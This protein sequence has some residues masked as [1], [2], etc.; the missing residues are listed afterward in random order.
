MAAVIPTNVVS[1]W[2]QQASPTPSV[3]AET[4]MSPPAEGG[5][6]PSAL[7]HL[8]SQ[9]SLPLGSPSLLTMPGE[10]S[11]KKDAYS[12]QEELEVAREGEG[13]GGEASNVPPWEE[14]PGLP[15]DEQGEGALLY[16]RGNAM[17]ASDR[18][19]ASFRT[20][21]SNVSAAASFYSASGDSVAASSQREFLR[22][23]SFRSL[24][25]AEDARERADTAVPRDIPRDTSGTG[26]VVAG[27]DSTPEARQQESSRQSSEAL[28]KL[29]VLPGVAVPEGSQ[30]A[31]L[32]RDDDANV[33]VKGKE[34]ETGDSGNSRE[35]TAAFLKPAQFPALAE[36]R[37]LTAAHAWHS[38]PSEIMQGHAATAVAGDDATPGEAQQRAELGEQESG[39]GQ[40]Q[41]EG[42]GILVQGLQ[43]G[44]GEG[45]V[46][47]GKVK[48]ELT[49][50]ED[51]V[52][53][54]LP[55]VTAGSQQE[56]EA[57]VP[58][59]RE[60]SGSVRVGNSVLP[61]NG[62]V[63]ATVADV[64]RD[65]LPAV[66]A[67]L[68][69]AP[70]QQVLG[71]E[72]ASPDLGG[73]ERSWEALA[74]AAEAAVSGDAAAASDPAQQLPSTEGMETAVEDVGTHAAATL[75]PSSPLKAL[76]AEGQLALG[77]ASATTRPALA[78]SEVPGNVHQQREVLRDAASPLEGGRETGETNR[79]EAEEEEKVQ[80]GAE[81][82]VGRELAEG[83]AVG[84][85]LDIVSPKPSSP[86]LATEQHLPGVGTNHLSKLEVPHKPSLVSQMLA[87]AAAGGGGEGWQGRGE[88]GEGS[89]SG[90][91]SGSGASRMSP[92]EVLQ[93]K[94]ALELSSSSGSS[95]S[96]GKFW[97]GG[98]GSP[99]GGDA[100]G[101]QVRAG[102]PTGEV[103]TSHF[104][105]ESDSRGEEAPVMHIV[106][107]LDAQ[108]LLS[109]GGDSS[110]MRPL[111]DIAPHSLVGHDEGPDGTVH[112]GQEIA[113]ALNHD[114]GN[115]SGSSKHS[116]G[117]SSGKEE[118]AVPAQVLPSSP[119]WGLTRLTS[120]REAAQKHLAEAP[121][122]FDAAGASDRGAA[123]RGGE[124]L[125]AELRE[126]Q[127]QGTAADM[128]SSNEALT[129]VLAA[130]YNVLP[131]DEWGSRTA[132]PIAAAGA[133]NGDEGG[134]GSVPV[135][136]PGG[137]QGTHEGL[138]ITPGSVAQAIHAFEK[139]ARQVLQA[140]DVLG[141]FSAGRRKGGGVEAPAPAAA[142]AA[143]AGGHGA[144]AE[145][146]R[147]GSAQELQVG[148]AVAA[149]AVALAKGLA[150]AHAAHASREADGD[151]GGDAAVTTLSAVSPLDDTRAG[152][153]G[154]GDA[155]QPI[156]SDGVHA[157]S[158]SSSRTYFPGVSSMSTLG[159]TRQSLREG[160]MEE[161]EQEKEQGR[162]GQGQ[163][164]GQGPLGVSGSSA[165]GAPGGILL[166]E[167]PALQSEE[168]EEEDEE[169]V[170]IAEP[171]DEGIPVAEPEEDDIPIAEPDDIPIA[172]YEEDDI[173]I[174]E[175]D[176][177][178]IAE[179]DEEDIPIAKPDDIPLAVPDEEDIPIAE[180]DDTP[181][182]EP[183]E[184][185]VPIAEPDD[186]PLAKPDESIPVAEPDDIPLAKPDPIPLAQP[187]E[188]AS[189]SG[190]GR[191]NW[192]GK[193]F[194]QLVSLQRSHLATFASPSP[195]RRSSAP[196][197]VRAGGAGGGGAAIPTAS[198][199]MQ[200][201][202][203]VT[204]A[205]LSRAGP[206]GGDLTAAV[207][208]V[209][210]RFAAASSP[211]SGAGGGGAGGGIN[212][213]GSPVMSGP[214]VARKG[215][216]V[217]L[218]GRSF[219]E[220]EP[221]IRLG[222]NN[223][224]GLA[225]TGGVQSPGAQQARPGL[226]RAGGGTLTGPSQAGNE[227]ERRVGSTLG[228]VLIRTAG[229]DLTG[230]AHPR[231]HQGPL[232]SSGGEFSPSWRGRGDSTGS[233]GASAQAPEPRTSPGQS[234]RPLTPPAS[235]PL[236]QVASSG[237]SWK[238]SPTGQPQPSVGQPSQVQS[239]AL[240][241]IRSTNASMSPAR[242]P[243]SPGGTPRSGVSPELMRSSS[244]RSLEEIGVR[245][246]SGA[247]EILKGMRASSASPTAGGG[248]RPA[249]SRA[250]TMGPGVVGA[251]S[252]VR[253]VPAHPDSFSSPHMG[254]GSAKG[255]AGGGGA[256]GGNP[257]SIDSMQL[258]EAKL[259][260]A[261]RS[262]S[263][264][265]KRQSSKSLLG[266]NNSSSKGS[267]A[268]EGELSPSASSM[269]SSQ[270]WRASRPRRRSP[271]GLFGCFAGSATFD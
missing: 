186:I 49:V 217:S 244:L 154:G 116:R 73:E 4:P 164:Q 163:E 258:R 195:I 68:A 107:P 155:S 85:S 26:G 157:Y 140:Q 104:A 87:P 136:S 222:G 35:A 191:G 233:P 72:E 96:R 149:G 266:R 2:L 8:E 182:A 206:G 86:D 64:G 70:R 125:V 76:V 220:G 225:R 134:G 252:L 167:L 22:K 158:D 165:K 153:R 146:S 188:A 130:A 179:P 135:L 193:G 238:D 82:G 24:A 235:S 58:L 118:P 232:P 103:A 128:P 189:V 247:R 132:A 139:S 181:L 126:E 38:P 131:A 250:S 110:P 142:A 92:R 39:Q 20:A 60:N 27:M 246:N 152:E 248:A 211:A 29:V 226:S 172:E 41:E 215:V 203:L 32:D 123:A 239:P 74:A 198:P 66:Q 259:R 83:P 90:S 55:V 161:Q 25:S 34:G 9:P 117:D 81:G 56:T 75:H 205:V 16:S 160:Q 108:R 144:P 268:S 59:D 43:E 42:A 228:P 223:S 257:L 148:A 271:L 120:P 236:G 137:V 264:P 159:T 173:P 100:V 216:G 71:G 230:T 121:G 234:V 145:G 53:S 52:R 269:A 255:A 218:A 169:D 99:K 45:E 31:A 138:P 119:G 84:M 270:G 5:S 46:G 200:T 184:E 95:R 102:L 229:G 19:V 17:A 171:N 237:T 210:P 194:D 207:E 202:R 231:A 78:G 50:V 265:M 67:T 178:P 245:I 69:V 201:N 23:G 10:G 1:S 124:A 187:V 44:R 105:K 249:L 185:N 168:D 114:D 175:P 80:R 147:G 176:D 224:P 170:P 54:Q 47:E 122:G 89:G 93:R 129:S 227:P 183:E 242:P 3:G 267:D 150:V 115:N 213:P 141:R 127:Q 219:F 18:S 174:A 197:L 143:T 6:P 212:L 196:G 61:S 251:E 199:L 79:L 240:A 254:P 106:S 208:P 36:L 30:G 48:E 11:A 112:G 243:Q 97:G 190:P 65:A 263:M 133:H 192:G 151:Q 62:A 63:Q 262:V 256:V 113:A 88:G 12:G 28:Q 51:M 162:Q 101:P 98:R 57:D 177:I 14:G 40:R 260:A 261:Q 214:R 180:P 94:A 7:G 77:D 109:H 111:R 21:R 13:G 37:E 221:I 166:P 33:L 15:S 209:D 204:G 156:G 253:F 91:G 241:R